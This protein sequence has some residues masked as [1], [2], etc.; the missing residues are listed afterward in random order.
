MQMLG[1]KLVKCGC[2]LMFCIENL[3]VRM[4]TTTLKFKCAILAYNSE[5]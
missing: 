4:Q 1:C 2:K 5:V 3:H